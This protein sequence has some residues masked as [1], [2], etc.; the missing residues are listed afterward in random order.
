M[1]GLVG[2]TDGM[3][4]GALFLMDGRKRVWQRMGDGSNEVLGSTVSGTEL[5]E[6]LKCWP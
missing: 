1:D 3:A 6:F 2:G 4:R 5:S